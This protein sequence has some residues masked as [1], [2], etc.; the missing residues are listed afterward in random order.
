MQTF[1]RDLFQGIT[2]RKELARHMGTPETRIQVSSPVSPWAQDMA[3]ESEGFSPAE[4]LELDAHRCG[5]GLELG[6]GVRGQK[7]VGQVEG[8][9]PLVA[10]R[11]PLISQGQGIHLQKTALQEPHWA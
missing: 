9:R 11:A 7:L 6:L 4:R 5:L 3:Q 10:M 8:L 2:T 1:T